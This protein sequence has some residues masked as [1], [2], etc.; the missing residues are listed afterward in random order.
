MCE[1]RVE[2]FIQR[3]VSQRVVS[4]RVVSQ[5]VVSKIHVSR[6]KCQDPCVKIQV[7]YPN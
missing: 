4:Q 1:S 7:S 5:R 3:V 6:S 2:K